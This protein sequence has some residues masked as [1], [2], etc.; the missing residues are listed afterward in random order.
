MEMRRISSRLTSFYKKTFPVVGCVAV[1]VTVVMAGVVVRTG[2]PGTSVF[3]IMPLL[4]LAVGYAIYRNL[5]SGLVDEVWLEGD[6]IV[7]KNRDELAKIALH[8]VTNVDVS[9][10]M[11]PRRITL[12]L[13]HETRWG[14]RIIFMP[15]VES[16][17]FAYSFKPDPIAAELT[18]RV[19]ALRTS[20][21]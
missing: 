6:A 17:G 8:D 15:A 21:P 14:N 7:V 18:A 13:R 19:D 2:R 1:L 20:A 3:L 9:S 11:N 16:V 12:T 10:M 5:V 4:M